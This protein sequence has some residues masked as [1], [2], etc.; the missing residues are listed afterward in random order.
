MEIAS[1]DQL[2]KRLGGTSDRDIPEGGPLGKP[3]LRTKSTK[4]YVTVAR[5]SSHVCRFFF[6]KNNALKEVI[7][8]FDSGDMIS[9]EFKTK[10]RDVEVGC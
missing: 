2:P 9:Y 1:P 7:H 10:V 5:S 6:L 3:K 4:G 8:E